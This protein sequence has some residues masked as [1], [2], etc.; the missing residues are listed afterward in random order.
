M[1]Y[2]FIFF[3]FF[4][5]AQNSSIKSADNIPYIDTSFDVMKHRPMPLPSKLLK[6]DFKVLRRKE[7]ILYW[8]GR[9]IRVDRFDVILYPGK[10]EYYVKG[11]MISEYNIIRF[12]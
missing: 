9:K 12:L 3:P 6:T 1:K 5:V 11:K 10:V 8:D 4:C 2:L 7:Q